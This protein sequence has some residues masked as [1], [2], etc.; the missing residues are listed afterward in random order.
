MVWSSDAPGCACVLVLQNFSP[1]ALPVIASLACQDSSPKPGWQVATQKSTTIVHYSTK[2]PGVKFKLQEFQH[3]IVEACL[4]LSLM[5][6][7]DQSP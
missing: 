4:G 3:S 7:M 1:T 5:A 6:C 2:V